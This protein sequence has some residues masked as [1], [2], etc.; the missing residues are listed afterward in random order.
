MHKIKAQ[1]S[2]EL[3][4]KNMAILQHQ[5]PTLNLETADWHKKKFLKKI[6]INFQKFA[7]GNLWTH[8][9]TR[10]TALSMLGAP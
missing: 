9:P 5:F 10:I 2:G 8:N 4:V 7:A 3:F 6:E 1:R